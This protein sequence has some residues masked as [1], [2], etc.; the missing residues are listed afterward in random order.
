MQRVA[1]PEVAKELEISIKSRGRD[2]HRGSING[3]E[4]SDTS[5]QRMQAALKS[6]ADVPN[7]FVPYRGAPTIK[8]EIT[9]SIGG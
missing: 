5:W 4:R 2:S 3:S 8:T 1:E 6:A 9:P 7:E